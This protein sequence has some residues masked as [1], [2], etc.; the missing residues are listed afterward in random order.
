M[1]LESRLVTLARRIRSEFNR[2]TDSVGAA[3]GIAPLNAQ[4]I[5][6][7]IHLPRHVLRTVQTINT[8]PIN[9]ALGTVVNF[10]ITANITATPA[11]F[12]N[13]IVGDIHV[14]ILRN[15]SGANRTL[16]LP[17]P[18]Q[19]HKSNVSAITVNNNQRRRMIGI[20]DGTVWDWQVDN[21]KTL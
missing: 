14:I 11:S 19:G 13:P 20:W 9:F 10:N 3:E 21:G 1:S 4:N 15:A 12:E 7:A 16:T 18:V 17:T 5:V 2:W 6:P 8:L